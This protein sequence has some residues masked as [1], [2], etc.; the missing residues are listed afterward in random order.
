LSVIVALG[1]GTVQLAHFLILW[2]NLDGPWATFFRSIELDSLG[3]V[4][5]GMFLVGWIA[6][7][8]YWRFGRFEARY[9]HLHPLHAHPHEHADGV[10]H[11]HRHFH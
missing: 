4:I 7:V 6:A 9:A 8:A 3:Y 5:V 2:R 1:I 11:V 10:S